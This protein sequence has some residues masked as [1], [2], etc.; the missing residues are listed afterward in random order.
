[1]TAKKKRSIYR[2]EVL[3]AQIA[4]H[5]DVLLVRPTS[6]NVVTAFIV[7]LMACIILYLALGQYTK[8]TQ[9]KGVLK[10][11]SGVRK[12]MAYQNGVIE[13]LLVKEGDEVIE[14]QPLYQIRTDRQGEDGSVAAE[15]MVS[16]ERSI[17]L[18]KEKSAFQQ[19]LNALEL[20]QSRQ[21]VATLN[22]EAAQVDDEIALQKDYL[23]LLSVELSEVEKLLRA[24]QISKSEYNAKY[25]QVLEKRINLKNLSRKKRDFKTKAAEAQ[26]QQRNIELKGNTMVVGYQEQLVALERELATI[27]ADKSYMIKAPADG[28]VAN[29]FYQQGHFAQTN[30][31][32]MNILPKD[33]QLI[34]EIY[35]P[36]SAIGL[37]ETGQDILLRY[38]AFP[39]Q[40]FGLHHGKIEQISKTLIEPFQAEVDSLIDEPSYRATVVLELQKIDAHGKLMDLQ[41]GMLLDADVIGDT[42][43]LFAW[44]FEPVLSARLN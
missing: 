15:R 14:G 9:V 36:T 4:R 21:K 25:A 27:R 42:R 8:S 23:R 6:F 38:H 26:K 41:P 37:V 28:V 10:T 22:H 16:I 34:A 30:K 32:L 2:R 35:I 31:P 12:I 19:D 7:V 43:S 20:T 5:G 33:A 11:P 18:L 1:M 40:K 13:S 3:E 17:E 39:F 24:K 44:I 29:V